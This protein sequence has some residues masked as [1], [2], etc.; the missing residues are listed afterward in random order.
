ME[1]LTLFLILQAIAVRSAPL[2][3]RQGCKI[4]TTTRNVIHATQP[5][6]I[7]LEPNLPAGQDAVP[8]VTQS[9]TPNTANPGGVFV[10][11]STSSV[12]PSV[13]VITTAVTSGTAQVLPTLST[14]KPDTSGIVSTS[15]QTS[16]RITSAP[17]ISTSIPEPSSSLA[18]VAPSTVATLTVSTPMAYANIFLP[19]A[20]GPPA[21]AISSRSD[22]PVPRLGIKPQNAPLDTNKFYANFF[23]GTQSAPTWTHPYSVQWAKGGGSSASWGMSISHIDAN[24]K[25]YGPGNPAAYFIN[26]NGIQSL[27]LSAAELGT[28]TTLTTDTLTAFS[29]NVN[30][31]PS[32]GAAPAITF[33]LV[34][35][36][37]FV[38]A[39]YTG[40]TPI[41]QTGVF[42]RSIVRS[43]VSPKAGVTK[44]TITL[45]D[46]KTWMLYAYSSS[47]APLDLKVVNNGLAQST[48]NWDGIIQIAKNPSGA[49]GLALLDAAVGA[50]PTTATITGG[51]SGNA[52][53]YTLSFTKAG[54][55]T[56]TLL[57]FALPHHVQSFS[58]ATQG[59]VS[60]L[61]LQTTTKGIATAVVAD[62][63][64]LV[65]PNMPINMD[66]APWTP[67]AGS[68]SNLSANAISAISKAAT[69]EI[70]QN[71]DT[72]T[73]GDSFY[74]SG[75]VWLFDL[76]NWEHTN[77]HRHW[78][79]ML[80]SYMPPMTL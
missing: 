77:R 57:M 43:S 29:V 24:Q 35:G 65:E 3:K 13:P 5:P 56:S 64:T 22:H 21:A 28:S 58:P 63:W 14:Q 69:S 61:Q 33:P 39:I 50:Y 75:K 53:T 78:L 18:T 67:D 46:G 36:M 38:T 52:G 17:I 45:E 30:L 11:I 1:L 51:V 7:V 72:Y 19:V 49:A 80:K 34:Q 76:Q 70:A 42:F 73:A 8:Y 31:S 9:N 68:Q 6:N 60:K 12:I 48:S 16:G 59:A 44:Y 41:L 25:V 4:P 79:S 40:G 74:F 15:L 2:E 10:E 20:T 54:L 71:Y 47:G 62:S 37:G 26:P 23:L 27:V 55:T 32:A 66:F